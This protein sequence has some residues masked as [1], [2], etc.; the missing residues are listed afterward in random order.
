MR[1]WACCEV[2]LVRQGVVLLGRVQN[3]ASAQL[4][5]KLLRPQNRNSNKEVECLCEAQGL[6]GIFFFLSICV[7]MWVLKCHGTCGNQRVVV[8]PSFPLF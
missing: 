6:E 1:T 4:F 7:K 2:T 8:L 5:L 3:G